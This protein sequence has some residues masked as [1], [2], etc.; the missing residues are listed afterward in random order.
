MWKLDLKFPT[1]L[2]VRLLVDHPLM[3]IVFPSW[4]RYIQILKY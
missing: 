2:L 1:E 4:V 3:L